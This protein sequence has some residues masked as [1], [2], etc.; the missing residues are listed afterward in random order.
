MPIRIDVLRHGIAEPFHEDG[1]DARPLTPEGEAAIHALGLKLKITNWRPDLAYSSPFRRAQQTL[2]LLIQSAAL[3]LS[4]QLMSELEHESTPS[5]LELALLP[6]LG[7]ARHVLL[8]SHQPLVGILAKHWT[9]TR[10]PFAPGDLLGIEFSSMIARG[11]GRIV[12]RISSQ[13]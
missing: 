2:A 4:P 3:A 13:Q 7:K 1:D 10:V 9:G 5:D 8:V 6:T 11:A 12:E